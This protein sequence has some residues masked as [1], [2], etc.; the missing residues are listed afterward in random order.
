MWIDA[1]VSPARWR[2]I[3]TLVFAADAPHARARYGHTGVTGC[4]RAGASSPPIT[5]H[6]YPKVTPNTAGTPADP[7]GVNL[8]VRIKIGIP[9]GYNPPLV[10]D[11]DVWF[12]EGGLYN[13][14]QYATC[15]RRLLDTPRGP[16]A[17]PPGSIMGSGTGVAR[18]DLTPTYPKITVVNGGQT[19]VYFY[20][21]L[22]N[23]ARVAE[24]APGTITKLSG[25]WSYKLHVV[26][27]R[28]LRIVAG[29]PIVLH[30][31]NIDAGR[32]DWMA[33]TYCPPDRKWV[34]K[35]VTFFT[36]GQQLN[37][38]GAVACRP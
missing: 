24:P 2:S 33:T 21:V 38:N 20:T 30:S 9:E 3:D 28:N 8:D 29:T 26:I 19:A 1:S 6:V 7:Q 36:N 22:N 23:P 31:L 10:K 34:W 4:D 27:P 25:S 17:C 16:R 18:A 5:V 13:G 37:S 12:P 11:I 15:S 32:G 35:A 14:D